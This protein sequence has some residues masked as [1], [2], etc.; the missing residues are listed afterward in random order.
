MMRKVMIASG[1]SSRCRS[2]PE[3]SLVQFITEVQAVELVRVV[4]SVGERTDTLHISGTSDDVQKIKI[5]HRTYM[6]NVNLRAQEGGY[7]HYGGGNESRFE[8]TL[9]RPWY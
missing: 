4:S 1:S 2:G 9:K 5:L 8:L 6:S 3:I 7:L